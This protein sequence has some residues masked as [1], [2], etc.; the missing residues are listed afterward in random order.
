MVTG[1]MI[2]VIDGL[3]GLFSFWSPQKPTLPFSV[4]FKKF[5]SILER[6]NR[7]LELMS[8]MGDKLG[9]DYVF[10]RQYVLDI[11]EKIGDLVF[12]LISDL[13]VMTQNENVDLFIA[14]ER[15]QHEIQ[16]EL[17]GRRAFPMTRPTV[18]LDE[19][20][21]DLNEEVGNK[22]ANLGDIRNTLGLPTM[23]GF[24]ITTR[25]FFDFMEAN[26]LLS[27]VE[28]SLAALDA[29][30][31]A[32]FEAMCDDV[33]GRILKGTIPR[34]V[35]SSMNGM[36]DILESR[37]RGK[38][39]RFAVRSSA[40]GEDSEFSFAGQ[41][42]SVL[43]VPR[44][45]I[46]EA[47][48]RVLAGAYA[49][50]AW[51]YRLHRGYRESEMAMAVGCQVMVEAEVS[52]AMYTYAPLPLEQEA[53]VI[54]AAWGLGPAVVEGLAES[55]TFVLDRL[56][57]HRLLSEELGRK[58]SKMVMEPDG[59]TA[60]DEVPQRLRDEP[61]LSSEYIQRLAQA[62]I[63]IERY[64]RR[65][66]DVEWAF[67]SKGNLYILQSRPLNVRP[68]QPER[69]RLYI[70][71]AT[72][73]A[74]V[75]FSGKGTVVQGGVASGKVYVA[76]TDD[77]LRD[78]PYGAILVA[79]YTSPKYSR[80]MRKARGILTDVGSATG[81]M[82]T[83][84]R[85]YRVPTVV[86][87]GVATKVLKTGD[88]VTLDA[89]R[90]VVYEGTVKE[91]SQFEITQ[92]EVFEESYEYRMLRRV[93]KKVNPLNLVDPHSE[94]F[95]AAR[96]QTF[97]DITRFVHEKAVER[98][99]D[100]SENYQRYHDRTPKRLESSIPLGLVIIDIDKG[101]SVPAQARSVTVEQIE[102]TPMKA[103]LQG[104]SESGMWETNPVAVDLGS[105]M[106][107]FT[108]TF[109]SSL[110]GPEQV[111]RNLAVISNNYM[112]LHL[113]LG[114]HFNILDAYIGDELNDNYI[115]FRFL[116]GVSNLQRRSRRARFIAEVMECFDFR[117][118]VH[119]DLIVGRLKKMSKEWMVA[120]MKVIGG[121][122][123]YTRQL[124]VS[125]ISD[126][127]VALHL[128]EFIK[129]IQVLTEVRDDVPMCEL[130]S[131]DADSNP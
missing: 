3:K 119:G 47:Y 16:E 2:N 108:R 79:R 35:I 124:D 130:R 59:G 78:F 34:H 81:H 52:G 10:D 37:A 117:V 49:P 29:K 60:W 30:D 8:D 107:S 6:N 41:Y 12:K 111:G 73:S 88:E 121:L 61:C 98:L 13:C 91:L 44:K 93:L 127:Q 97:H 45:G 26:G 70:D 55:D 20:N 90:N 75:L 77:D 105:L 23:D 51:R 27:H 63:M 48:R 129:R 125:M 109:S 56:P 110:A 1:E 72:L 66:Q 120:K 96:C 9:G 102:S 50:E 80:V 76:R 101:T 32:A 67:D 85:E 104:L 42:E 28:N 19:L 118:E 25:A 114:Y 5:R 69:H 43:N 39:L 31:E 58:A 24:V 40:W 21:G 74:H 18:L 11:S 53:M 95:K 99:I 36:L 131:K 68:N 89:L 22:F 17:A 57:P 86:D 92:E 71:Q 87:T 14:F 123:G 106:S 4:L 112:N 113:R 62:A 115:Y 54:S 84:A 15:I 33:R 82:A 46:A 83:L 7:I 103:L 122:I 116:G 65:P 128:A 38:P 100:L 94:Y 64:Y 126:E